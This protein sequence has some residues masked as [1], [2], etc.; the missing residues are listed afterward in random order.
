MGHDLGHG[1]TIRPARRKAEAD[2]E[3]F[4]AQHIAQELVQRGVD[5]AIAIGH[6]RHSIPKEN[7]CRSNHVGN[8]KHPCRGARQRAGRAGGVLPENGRPGQVC[9]TQ[10]EEGARI[11]QAGDGRVTLNHPRAR[12]RPSTHQPDLPEITS[13]QDPESG[14][15]I[16]E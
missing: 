2:D 15:Q 13:R 10:R 6:N 8:T 14:I 12:F 3:I 5:K 7:R 1:L 11:G 4:P 9:G 16:M